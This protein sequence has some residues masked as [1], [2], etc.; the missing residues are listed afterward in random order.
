MIS[1]GSSVARLLN[2]ASRKYSSNASNTTENLPSLQQIF[3]KSPIIA[4]PQYEAFGTPNN[5]NDGR[6][7][8]V[9]DANREGAAPILGGWEK[10]L[11]P[12]IDDLEL[13]VSPFMDPRATEAKSQWHSPKARPS[14]KPTEFQI[15]LAKNQ[16]AQMLATPIRQCH[17][18]KFVVPSFFLQE[19]NTMAHPVTQQPWAVPLNLTKKYK[20][21]VRTASSDS[22]VARAPYE[23][24]VQMGDN[25][26]RL[27]S[28]N[29]AF[30]S[31][32]K[33]PSRKPDGPMSDIG[34]GAKGHELPAT[35]AIPTTGMNI[36]L[37][38]AIKDTNTSR[39]FNIP[40]AQSKSQ[41]LQLGS[42]YY[43]MARQRLIRS[44]VEDKSGYQDQ[45][46]RM[47]S[48]RSRKV[49][50]TRQIKDA[51]EWRADMDTLILELMRR[52]L[53]E[54][55]DYMTH[56]KRGYITGSASWGDATLAK[57]QPGA[58]L[59][60]GP[61]MPES[62][63]L[64]RSG[65]AEQI[66]VPEFSTLETGRD[67]KKVA[68]FNLRRLL[69]SEHL[70]KLRKESSIFRK[71][72]VVIRDKRMTIELRMKLWKLEGYMATYSQ[73]DPGAIANTLITPD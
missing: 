7:V 19:F 35:A 23:V 25:E 45:W 69:G 47:S 15:Q 18:T 10:Y 50:S 56:L 34:N 33:S 55:L 32:A 57:R 65:C 51:T 53:G 29:H 12:S 70:T 64:V 26:E 21:L 20:P 54:H 11:G 46:S 62:D 16:Y 2:A 58:I 22:N 59:W 8:K 44:F 42:S 43:V 61:Y 73:Y 30:E 49:V 66:S 3:Q 71:E 38:P 67:K 28:D 39:L 1:R 24:N 6:G 27:S 31:A 9:Q 36:P 72:I 13:P 14:D 5:S 4:T 63:D 41:Q 60:T 48:E 40:S 37:S 17:A 68:V 52:R